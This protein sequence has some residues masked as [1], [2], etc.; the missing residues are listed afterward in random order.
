[1]HTQ[2][3]SGLLEKLSITQCIFILLIASGWILYSQHGA[4][5]N[6]GALYLTQAHYFALGDFESAKKLYSWP[7]FSILIWQVHTLTPLSYFYAAQ[8]I[9]ITLFLVACLFFFKTLRLVSSQNNILLAGLIVLMTS[10]PFMDD[11]LVM[12]LR[13]NGSWAGFMA[14]AYYFLSWS[15]HRKFYLAVLWQLSFLVATFFRPEAIILNLLL[16]FASLFI[17]SNWK[18]KSADFFASTSLMI[19]IAALGCGYLLYQNSLQQVE[20]NWARLSELYTRPK[21][22]FDQLLMPL[23]ISTEH[24]YLVAL[25]KK[26][27]LALKYGFLSYALIMSWLGA[28]T[29]L[30]AAAAFTA[31][32]HRLL[33]T[34]LNFTFCMLFSLTFLI[35]FV[36]GLTAFEAHGRYWGM[37]LWLVYVLSALGI[38]HWLEQIY[39]GSLQKSRWLKPIFVVVIIGYMLTVL[40]DFEQRSSDEGAAVEWIR[41]NKIEMN[42]VYFSGRRIGA[43]ASVYN[44]EI[45]SIDQ[46][47]NQSTQ[48]LVIV[49]NDKNRGIRNQIEGYRLVES[50][51]NEERSKV[52]IYK[53][54]N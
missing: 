15:K 24:I 1:M 28:V 40:F 2:S 29:L 8:L 52:D 36:Y 34:S 37:N 35:T 11:H 6:D 53:K 4:M 19:V 25:V 46:A 9:N 20:I 51:P 22:F 16:P 44:K 47:V 18:G 48:Y 5:N 54:D 31:V 21:A 42:D 23:P 49:I 50:F 41:E 26:H 45:V 39:E 38:S 43:R 12:L 3:S 33:V 7:F 30:H 10:I 32:K 17:S 27:G 13:D 14:G